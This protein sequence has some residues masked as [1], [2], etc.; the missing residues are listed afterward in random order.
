M[1]AAQAVSDYHGRARTYGVAAQQVQRLVAGELHPHERCERA[2]PS[3]GLQRVRREASSK[4]DECSLPV[5]SPRAVRPALA[6][7]ASGR[8]GS[9]RARPPASSSCGTAKTPKPPASASSLM[10]SAEITPHGVASCG[11]S[12][13]GGAAPAGVGSSGLAATNP[14]HP[15]APL[16]RPALS[17]ASPRSGADA[18]ASHGRTCGL[19]VA[20]GPETPGAAP[21]AGTVIGEM[22][23]RASWP[24]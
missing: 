9:A 6:C 14:K 2:G 13:A 15:S 4:M 11:L 7:G 16:P 20:W 17:M 10:P 18:G 8:Q 23:P 19:W 22:T 3:A 24:G 21:V 12:T 5:P 1:H